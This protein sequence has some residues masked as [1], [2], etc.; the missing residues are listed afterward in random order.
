MSAQYGT[1]YRFSNDEPEA[2]L[3]EFGWAA[4]VTTLGHEGTKHGRW[5]YPTAPR[6]VAGMPHGLLVTATRSS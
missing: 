6:G 1:H 2:L 5:P 3:A 4:E